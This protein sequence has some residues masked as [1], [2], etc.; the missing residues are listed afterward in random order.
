[1]QKEKLLLSTIRVGIFCVDPRFH[2]M[3]VEAKS[4]INMELLNPG[5]IETAGHFLWLCLY[6][7]P[8]CNDQYEL[9]C[10]KCPVQHSSREGW[11]QRVCELL[12]GMPPCR[13]EHFHEYL[14]EKATDAN[15][16]PAVGGG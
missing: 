12:R 8:R 7:I 6:F 15:D 5:A 4:W 9:E 2:P 13:S 11:P 1:M 14:S 10:G 16:M 3:S